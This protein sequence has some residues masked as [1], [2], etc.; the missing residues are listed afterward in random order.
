[1]I[2]E[3]GAQVLLDHDNFVGFKDFHFSVILLHEEDLVIDFFTEL[4][5]VFAFD[6]AVV[7]HVADV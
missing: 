4:L 6:Q 2:T 7:E 5:L 1:M 3:D